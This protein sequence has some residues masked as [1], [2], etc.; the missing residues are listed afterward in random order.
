MQNIYTSKTINT[1]IYSV[2]TIVLI[3]VL[4]VTT[5]G[6]NSLALGPISPAI[7]EALSISV[8]EVM[9]AAAA[10]GIGTALA[11]FF[12][13]SRIDSHGV[14]KVLSIAI[15][16]MSAS[17]LLSALAPNIYILII[18]QFTAGLGAGTALPAIYA[19]AAAIA[20]AGRENAVTGQVLSGWTLSLVAGVS[21]AS[22]VADFL[23]W[24]WVYGI[25][26][27]LAMCSLLLILRIPAPETVKREGTKVSS[28]KALTLPR[29]R[30]LLVICFAYMAAFYGTYGYVGDHIHNVLDQAIS[31]S[32][33][34]A[35]SYGVG[36]GLAVFGDPLID[37]F[38][39]IRT[40]P[41]AYLLIA[42]VYLALA[43][44]WT[45]AIVGLLGSG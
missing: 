10:Y 14:L 38:G 34:I 18:A 39:A 42:F 5:I 45:L 21:L 22:V 41:K 35:I 28:F 11:A 37:R 12:L 9:T 3:L 43:Y 16:S 4:G 19:Y 29:A 7:S 17:F 13:A 27:I 44:F 26:T 40:M 23:H 32:G 24:R 25:F 36:F 33:L 20:P 1:E 2:N 30:P 31:A 8:P 6:S 15:A